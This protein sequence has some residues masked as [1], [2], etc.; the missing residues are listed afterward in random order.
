M[1]KHRETLGFPFGAVL[2]VALALVTAGGARDAQAQDAQR[3]RQAEAAFARILAQQNE[4]AEPAVPTLSSLGLDG[5][6]A[7][8]GAAIPRVDLPLRLY[9]E[10]VAGLETRRRAAGRVAG[11]AVVIGSSSYEGE[12]VQGALALRL[13]LQLTLGRPGQWKTVP[14]VGEDVILTRA[15]VGEEALTVSSRDGYQVW[16]TR[17]S[18]EL[19]LTLDLLVPS[20][21]PRGSIEYDFIVVPTPVTRFS[22]R[23]P[24][25]GLEPRIDAAVH[26][27]FRSEGGQ[28][29]VT[30][31]LRP[32]ARVHLVG[33]R[34]LGGAEGQPAKVFSE[35]LSL[36]SVDEGALEVFTVVRYTILQA[37]ARDFLLAI[38]PEMTVVS[39]D[40]K[41]AFHH[42]LER[43]GGQT[44][45]RGETAFP[46]RNTY[47]VSLHLRREL[48]GDGETFVVPLPRCLGVEREM[49]WL[50]VEVPGKLRLEEEARGEA[51]AVDVR[52]LPREMVD[53]AV[54]PILAA[55][56]YHGSP[57]DLRLLAR[58]LPE[59]EPDSSAVDKVRAFTVLSP[60]GRILTEM[61]IILR[62]RFRHS[63]ALS[64][65]AGA[66]IRS[67]L[68][69]GQPVKASRDERG[70]LMIPLKRSTGGQRPSAFTLHVFF[71]EEAP[72]LDLYGSRSLALPGL[73]LPVS[74]VAWSVFLPANNTYSGLRGALSDQ[75]YAG[76]ANW[77][78]P[79]PTGHAAGSDAAEPGWDEND[80]EAAVFAESGAM[81][82]RINQPR[83]GIRLEYG[84]YWVV[85]DEPV[86]VSFRYVRSWLLTPASFLLAALLALGLGLGLRP[87]SRGP[88]RLWRGGGLVLAAAAL[89]PAWKLG[90]TFAV[91][92]A[93]IAAAALAVCRPGTLGPA[94]RAL[95]TWVAGIRDKALARWKAGG[96]WQLRRLVWK[97]L[98]GAALVA[99][100]A[101]ALTDGWRL[102]AATWEG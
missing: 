26:S 29:L 60:E 3:A 86:T 84:R 77:R 25:E 102:L 91:L 23:F 41:G 70:R 56:R 54:S 13:T 72:P 16:M 38:P 24:V 79:R 50:A 14:L 58:R 30:A 44:L 95:G 45:L 101:L 98:L 35:T 87:P 96:P 78:P 49:G 55:Y 85:G 83:T 80:G 93:A 52:Q 15:V 9:T 69:D 71:E 94:T 73:E 47:E 66:E 53:S 97:G 20:R 39:A 68:L 2:F 42:T 21:G 99:L 11:P 27:E 37:G 92:L 5:I 10:L 19:S 75:R 61:R 89:W 33:F 8:G 4:G 62:N 7:A 28:T 67:A 64:P 63:L 6:S 74:S 48:E 90:G 76:Q 88:R 40:G 82:V 81:P 59:L 32:T 17:E 31:I 57:G 43:K 22:C 12:A 36:V 18:G 65:R 100:A 51:L 46:I 1:Q 34:D